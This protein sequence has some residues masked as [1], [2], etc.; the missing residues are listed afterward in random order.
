MN[1]FLTDKVPY[2]F[3]LLVAVLGWFMTNVVTETKKM[4]LLSYDLSVVDNNTRPNLRLELRNDS[5][6]QVFSGISIELKC[7][8]DAPCLVA[9]D[10]ANP[11]VIAM[12]DLEPPWVVDLGLSASSGMDGVTYTFTPVM[13]A[14]ATASLT[15]GLADAEAKTALAFRMPENRQVSPHLTQGR[16]VLGLFSRHYFSILVIMGAVLILAFIIWAVVM[17]RIALRGGQISA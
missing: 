8:G 4:T 1:P 15:F 11:D 2:V 10:P 14:G 13:P 12:P 5:I 3:V 17:G 6:E 9:Q 16:S 7:L